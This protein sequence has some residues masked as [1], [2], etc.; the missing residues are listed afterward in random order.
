[1][2]KHYHVAATIAASRGIDIDAA[3]MDRAK[4]IHENES[5]EEVDN[6]L[7]VIDVD[8]SIGVVNLSSMKC[9]CI[10]AS[11][12]VKCVCLCVAQMVKS[13]T[14]DVIHEPLVMDEAVAQP[15]ESTDDTIN[16]TVQQLDDI[17]NWMLS[18]PASVTK[19][20]KIYL[21]QLHSSIFSK[22]K[23]VSRK[24]KIQSVN[25]S[26][27]AINRQKKRK[28]DH[29]YTASKSKRVHTTRKADGA[30][31]TKCRA[32]GAQRSGFQ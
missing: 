17:R 28:V 9:L 3:R 32:K 20:H 11:H 31:K 13:T 26:R 2:C 6:H 19:K 29:A 24:R 1:M 10:A 25:P 30:F 27:L 23:K 14:S 7:E 21:K 22:H 12:G 8:G 4:T 16:T 18:N 15:E 5:F